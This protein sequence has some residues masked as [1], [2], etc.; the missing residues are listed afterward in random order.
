MNIGSLFSLQG[1]LQIRQMLI[2][3]LMIMTTSVDNLGLSNH[4]TSG[5]LSKYYELYIKY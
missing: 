1:V 5:L 3:T 2:Q 4:A